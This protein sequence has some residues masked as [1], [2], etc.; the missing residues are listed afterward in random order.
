MDSIALAK[1]LR[2]KRESLCSYSP[3]CGY[4]S[5]RRYYSRD[6]EIRADDNGI[7]VALRNYKYTEGCKL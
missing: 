6:D 3:Y 2:L 4:S 5:C 7:S 1:I